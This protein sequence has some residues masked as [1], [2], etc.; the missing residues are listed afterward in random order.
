MEKSSPPRADEKRRRNNNLQG[1]TGCS[2]WFAT[3][4]TEDS[5]A[6]R[7]WMRRGEVGGV[8]RMGPTDARRSIATAHGTREMTIYR[9]I[10]DGQDGEIE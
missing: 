9:D 6:L 10:Q 2:G 8:A 4:S 7:G 5:E 1:Y 3:E